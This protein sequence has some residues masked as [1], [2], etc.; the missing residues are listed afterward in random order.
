MI[1]SFL[2]DEKISYIVHKNSDEKAR[3]PF[4]TVAPIDHGNTGAIQDGLHWGDGLHPLLQIKHGVTMYP[5]NLISIFMS[6]FGF[7]NKYHGNIYGVTGTLGEEAHHKF[8]SEVYQVVLSA[9][10]TFIEK[11]M[12]EFPP[13]VVETNSQWREKISDVLKRKNR[14]VSCLFSGC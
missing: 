13:I 9:I 3:Y 12:T 1:Y 4:L 5:E 10:P 8:L 2:I 7:F 6:Y 14:W 11:D